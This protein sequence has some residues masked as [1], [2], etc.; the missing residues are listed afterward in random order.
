MTCCGD[1][2]SGIYRT[3]TPTP[4]T[5][6]VTFAK[7]GYVTKVVT[8]VVLS[9][10]IV[11]NLNV[12]LVP[13][14]TVN[15]VGL[16]TNNVTSL[17][18][19]NVQVYITDPSN[20]YNFVSDGTGNFGACNVIGATDYDISAALWGYDPICLTN[21]TIS[22]SSSTPTYALDPGYYDDFTFNLGWTVTG[23][24][25]TGT[26]ERGVPLQTMVGATISNPGLDV[27]TDCNDMAYVTGNG[28]GSAASDDVD[29]GYTI[30]T[31]PIFDLTS[32]TT[33]YIQYYSWL[34]VGAV[35]TDSLS[36]YLS[37][38]TSTVLID[39]SNI[40][41]HGIL[42]YELLPMKLQV[43][44]TQAISCFLQHD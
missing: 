2:L 17:P 16:T 19:P 30:L 9:P 27:A 38:G 6:T 24:S 1:G 12:Q 34:Y 39:Y 25:S 26:W 22:V 37:N 31:S 35:S 44:L 10:G 32:Y 43:L 3:G 36:V 29:N 28:G 4:G 13:F 20:S 11:N 21:Q 14:N 42:L 18:L 23:T 8:G 7:S 40:S 5:Y 33:P 41:F 15:V